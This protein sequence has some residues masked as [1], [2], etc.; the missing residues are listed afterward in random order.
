[1]QI[2]KLKP[3]FSEKIW[4][5]SKLKDFGFEIP[6]N[7]KIGEAWVISA[8][9]N[10][11]SYLTDGLFKDQALKTVFEN[12]RNLFGNY[13]GE[14]PLLAKIITADD[15][16]SVQVHPDDQYAMA[17]HKQLG[18]P[19]SWYILDCPKDAKIIYGHTA[20]SKAELESMIENGKW[21]ELLKEE[22][23][24]PGDFLFVDTGKIHAIT[25]GVTVYEL[26]RSSDITYRLY[27]YDRLD[28]QSQPRRLDLQDSINCTIVPDSK[29][30]IIQN[31]EKK[32]F[33]SSV[34]SIYILNADQ[35]SEFILDEEA[36]WLQFTVISGTGTINDQHFKA[37]ESAISLGKL[38]PIKVTGNLQV[39]I[40]WIKK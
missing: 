5:C 34:F 7:K 39:I 11:M 40:S 22:S 1:M 6:E 12:N 19:E 37:G 14:Y 20:Q 28:D 13:Q 25:P 9:N 27:D 24:K 18:K 38:E 2:V 8:H 21:Q 4:G 31:A 36:S 32:I 16:L 29:S 17:K 3:F 26:Q 10:G 35:E 30:L 23:I 15:Y 33:S